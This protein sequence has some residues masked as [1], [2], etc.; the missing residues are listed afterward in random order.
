MSVRLNKGDA[1]LVKTNLTD[2]AIGLIRYVGPMVDHDMMSEYVGVQLLQSITNGHNGTINGFTYFTAKKG[3]GFHTK[4]TNVIKKLSIADLFKE[5]SYIHGLL[6]TKLKYIQRLEALLKKKSKPSRLSL[7]KD[8]F[9]HVS[10][11]SGDSCL[12]MRS[13]QSRPSRTL[14]PL[15]LSPNNTGPKINCKLS[16]ALST[17]SNVSKISECSSVTESRSDMLNLTT[18]ESKLTLTYAS[19][20]SGSECSNSESYSISNEE[21]RMSAQKHS[22]KRNRPRAQSVQAQYNNQSGNPFN[23][24]STRMHVNTNAPILVARHS[25]HSMNKSSEF[26]AM[27]H[28]PS[29]PQQQ[30]QGAIVCT[31]SPYATTVFN[32]QFT[33]STT[34]TSYR[35]PMIATQGNNA[36]YNCISPTLLLN[37]GYP[38]FAYPTDGRNVNYVSMTPPPR[39]SSAY[40]QPLNDYYHRTVPSSPISMHS[41]GTKKMYKVTYEPSHRR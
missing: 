8:Q 12:S 27:S 40:N 11:H 33:T 7:I 21:I 18:K 14:T 34:P 22:E 3:H 4:M 31:S 6:Q 38:Y 2:E 25:L 17:V 20:E 26:D 32:Q 41:P 5:T 23:H 35:P 39:S 9:Q 10:A 36:M 37:N 28:S 15:T 30:Q 1:V 24:S 19:S 16:N 29:P 13:M